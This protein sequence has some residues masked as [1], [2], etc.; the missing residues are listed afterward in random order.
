MNRQK[1]L[2][3]LIASV[4]SVSGLTGC[5]NNNQED[6]EDNSTGYYSSH[7]SGIS[8]TSSKPKSASYKSFL[9]LGSS[10]KGSVSS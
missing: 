6:D 5:S 3:M 7:Y 10:A 9:G 1:V 8:R 4:I 2:A